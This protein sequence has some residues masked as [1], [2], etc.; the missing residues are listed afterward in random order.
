MEKQKLGYWS[1]ATQKHLKT[2][3][4]DSTNLDELDSINIT[5]KTGRFIGLLRGNSYINN[6][7][8]IEKMAGTIGIH[9]SELHS[10]I[11]PKLEKVS[12]KKLILK[13]YT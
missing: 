2:F 8:K 11:L 9:R 3:Q 10:I 5:G 6:L 13:K 12:D 7:R 4:P 1:I